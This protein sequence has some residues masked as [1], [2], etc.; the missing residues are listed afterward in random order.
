MFDLHDCMAFIVN[1]S[2]KTFSEALEKKL[3]PFG[4]SKTRW[5][6]LYF[7]NKYDEL[8]QA[9]L[10]KLM[11]IKAPTVVKLLQQLE[12][13]EYIIRRIPYSDKREKLISLSK[14][15]KACFIKTNSIVKK[16]KDDIVGGI[17][18][19]DLE[20]LKKSIEKMVE[21]AEKIKKG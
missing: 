21:N 1:S 7:I 8:N 10:A 20:V 2:A 14:K 5:T 9:H 6:A 18:E 3:E 19:Q 15:G 12:E 16:F 4:V 11:D 17:S 13:E